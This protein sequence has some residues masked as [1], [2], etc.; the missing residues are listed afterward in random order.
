MPTP[1][2]VRR[3][4]ISRRL[5]VIVALSL[6][7]A[8]PLA[9]SAR[10]AVS[11]GRA[12]VGLVDFVPQ[13]GMGFQLRGWAY[14]PDTTSPV[15]IRVRVDGIRV[16]ALSADLP[17]PDVARA[18]PAYG[19]NRGF[20]LHWP[21]PVGTHQVC[22]YA[23]NYPSIARWKLGC[24]NVR[25]THKPHGRITL[26]KQ[27]PGSL[28]ARG[29][30]ID[31]D[32]PTR[33][34]VVSIYLDGAP[35]V[36]G[37]A[38]RN[39][40]RLSTTHPLSGPAHAFVLTFPVTEGTHTVCLRVA[41]AGFGVS[42]I[43]G[44]LQRAVTFSPVG[45]I[46][47]LVQVPG[48]IRVTGSASDA[49]TTSPIR[50]AITADGRMLGTVLANDAGGTAPGQGFHAA[51]PLLGTKLRPGTRTIC[52]VGRN[53]GPYG[54]DRAVQCIAHNFNW[55]PRARVDS[56]VQK[57]PGATITGW[58]SDPDTSRPI[59]VDIV[60]DGTKRTT[61]TANRTGA[62]HSGHRF[63]AN[64]PLPD[65][66]HSVCAVAVN[67]RYGSADSAPR[68]ATV[69]LAFEPYGRFESL[70]RARGSTNVIATGWAIDPDTTAAIG[71]QVS[72]DGRPG[73]HG[74]A[75]L[76]RPD[77]ADRH[78]GTGT[79]HGFAVSV[80]ATD[81][82]HRVCVW[83]VNVRGGSGTTSLGCRRIFAVHP[84]VTSAPRNVGAIAGYG[85][86]RIVWTAPTRDGGARWSGYA[87]TASP[88][89]N[90][91]TVAA[92]INAATILGLAP[93]TNYTFTVVAINVAG[94]SRAGTS[95]TVTTQKE[96]PAQTSPAPISTSRYI[97]NI[98]GSSSGDLAA[99]RSEGV[100][101]AR[102][103]P[104]GHGYLIVLAVGGQDESRNGVI[105]TAGI[106]Y[107]SY[108]DIVENLNAYVD[109]YASQQRP[110]AP[111][112]IAIATNNDIDV[113]RGSGVS[114]ADKVIDPVRWH[115]RRYPGITIAGS[116]DM[117]PGFRAT[118]SASRAWL[119]GYLSATR[120]PFVFTGSAD[121]CAWTVT[122]RACNN[123][124]SMSGLF[125]LAGGASAI[126]VVNL[127]QVYN[128]TMA[129][130]WRY[131][132]LTGVQAGQPKINFGGALTEWT[133]CRQARS[134]G[135]LT[136][137][138][139]WKQMWAQLRAEPALRPTSLPYSTDLRIDR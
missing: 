83:A 135:S 131:I 77:I 115:T 123:G 20:Q 138:S 10:A 13:D 106:R 41:N 32:A 59:A 45:A 58:A 78:P 11:G 90:T 25:I 117:E 118:Y 30:G 51:F 74:T 6:A 100:A 57:S 33:A 35:V 21:V 9:P 19:G 84:T 126:R 36:S 12:P 101:D 67:T 24:R 97:R 80:P 38:D 49:D 124:W 109:G 132:S 42:K 65:G 88:G 47:T 68:C 113:W 34:R 98:S 4:P 133:A 85:G 43:E 26:L 120:A 107:V 66:R 62:T 31:P 114:F 37:T 76:H 7:V 119:R 122:N 93:G 125:Y 99:M 40:A 89:G 17:R 27:R 70:T 54:Q 16:A 53:F 56:V 61:V 75:N 15:Q 71:V 28:T 18:H 103:N 82:E 129:Q 29:F 8:A 63:T 95:P 104:S 23:L 50:V 48:G 39:Y 102:A 64:V 128:S 134:C 5:T 127:P 137:N 136:G 116:D 139:A 105:L 81:G 108:R 79:A 91:T 121:G 52:A 55:N 72:V 92:G 130:Q 60:A 86:A 22:A 96:P 73:V 112:T 1:R 87:I 94:R 3:A 69:T 110:S 2:R 14:D 46:T 44:C 111:I